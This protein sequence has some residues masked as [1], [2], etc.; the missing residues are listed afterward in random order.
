MIY[1]HLFIIAIQEDEDDED[2]DLEILEDGVEE[3]TE[4]EEELC[5]LEIEESD[6]A[7]EDIDVISE[8]SSEDDDDDDEDLVLDDEET[9]CG[10]ES[11]VQGKYIF[12]H[13]SI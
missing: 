5:N 6:F 12:T 2:D 3:I 9:D 1:L 13:L 8:S 11:Q 7:E 10:S 4:A